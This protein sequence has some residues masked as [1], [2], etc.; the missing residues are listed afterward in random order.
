MNYLQIYIYKSSSI[1]EQLL[2]RVPSN[3]ILIDIRR[4]FISDAQLISTDTC[5]VKLFFRHKNNIFHLALSTSL[6]SMNTNI[7]VVK[8]LFRKFTY[9]IPLHADFIKSLIT[10]ERKKTHKILF[11]FM[12]YSLEIYRTRRHSK[13]DILFCYATCLKLHIRLR[14]I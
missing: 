8:K 9:K 3:L 1:S 14:L 10:N 13:K 7:S 6:V 4:L 12:T 11:P 5:Q 2:L